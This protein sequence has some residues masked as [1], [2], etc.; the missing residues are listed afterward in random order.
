MLKDFIEKVSHE[1]ETMQNAALKR[2]YKTTLGQFIIFRFNFNRT[3]LY[4]YY[5]DL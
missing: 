4:H 1:K 3:K 5:N 2:C